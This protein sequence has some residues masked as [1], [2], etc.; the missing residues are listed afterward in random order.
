MKSTFL[1]VGLAIIFAT[2]I[3]A[4]ELNNSTQ[5]TDNKALSAGVVAIFGQDEEF[6]KN[7]AKLQKN[8]PKTLALL[9]EYRSCLQKTN[10]KSDA[11]NC[12]KKSKAKADKLGLE[13]ED[14]D[15]IL[16]DDLGEWSGETKKQYLQELSED[17]DYMEE[18]MPCLQRA[19][20]VAEIIYCK[21]FGEGK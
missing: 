13:D 19:K 16:T 20:N 8:L 18:A 11:T 9:K 1:S 2:F 15:E 6:Q 14:L 7:F 12:Q 17:V 3:S 21:G 4:N 10:I 5:N